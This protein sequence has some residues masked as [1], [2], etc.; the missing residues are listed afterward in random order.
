MQTDEVKSKQSSQP[1]IPQVEKVAFGAQI[2]SKDS[3]LQ[4]NKVESKPNIV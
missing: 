1:Q 3:L 4:R 2:S